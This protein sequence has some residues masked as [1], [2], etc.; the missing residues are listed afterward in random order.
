MRYW[1][2]DVSWNSST[3]ATGYWPT[4]RARSA[5]PF[6][7]SSATFRRSSMSA[8][9][10]WRL[11]R[12]SS[13]MRA[14]I[15]P[16]A[17]RSSAWAIG[18]SA[19]RLACS[20]AVASKQ[21]GTSVEKSLLNASAMPSGVRRRH[22]VSVKSGMWRAGS[23]AHARSASNHL[24]S[25]S[26]R[27]LLPLKH[28]GWR[29]RCP[30]IQRSI[31][32]ARSNQPSFRRISSSRCALASRATSCFSGSVAGAP[33]KASRRTSSRTLVLSA[34]TSRQLSITTASDSAPSG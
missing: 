28:L 29:S 13:C 11:R 25:E 26:A 12:L 33:S 14:P 19:A 31:S 6:S 30:A 16:A 7:P 24:T 21:S 8:K 34:S 20:A 10:N 22:A 18:S 15:W 17:W 5:A 2:G 9:P 1:S 3:S 23:V 4:M 32:W 27:I